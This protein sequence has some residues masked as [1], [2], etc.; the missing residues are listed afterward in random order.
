MDSQTPV[1]VGQQFGNVIQ[2]GVQS[3]EHQR[4]LFGAQAFQSEAALAHDTVEHPGSFQVLAELGIEVQI[5]EQGQKIVPASKNGQGGDRSEGYVAP[6]PKL[7]IDTF[8]ARSLG[9][10]AEYAGMRKPIQSV[11]HLPKKFALA[12]TSGDGIAG[13]ADQRI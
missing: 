2:M 12:A 4:N 3:G 1:F 6:S 7:H 8:G 13:I 9:A 5:A 11:H 10:T